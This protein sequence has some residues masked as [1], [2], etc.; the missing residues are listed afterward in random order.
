[1]RPRPR[2][3]TSPHELRRPLRARLPPPAADLSALVLVQQE[4]AHRET[5]VVKTS[6]H[7]SNCSKNQ[8]NL[9]R[10]LTSS[11]VPIVCAA[12]LNVS[13]SRRSVTTSASHG[14]PTY[15]HR[16]SSF[17]A[18]M[19]SSRMP[20]EGGFSC[21][22]EVPRSPPSPLVAGGALVLALL[23]SDA[24]IALAP[25]VALVTSAV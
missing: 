1:V 10:V 13:R 15:R 18:S 24:A 8:R 21:G 5:E 17:T 16:S 20:R 3:T 2:P 6:W 22:L 4:T 12:S 14:V 11:M 19:P 7:S 9:A 25:A 23:A